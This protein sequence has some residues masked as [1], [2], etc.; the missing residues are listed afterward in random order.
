MLVLTR[1]AGESIIIGDD[2][3]LVVVEVRGDQ[4]RIGVDAP[5]QVSV[6]RGEVYE[7][8]RKANQEAGTPPNLQEFGKLIP[9]KR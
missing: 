2:V 5:R 9:K 7:A 4:V 6:H 8:I 1:K 3:R